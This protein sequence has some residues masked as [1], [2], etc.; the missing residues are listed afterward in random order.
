MTPPPPRGTGQER[1]ALTSALGKAI[2]IRRLELGLKRND[3]R[4]RSGLSY[5]YIAE[6]E[7]GSKAASSK[8]LGALAEALELSVSELMARAEEL[9]DLGSSDAFALSSPREDA[10]EEPPFRRASRAAPVSSVRS[11]AWRSETRRR[12]FGSDERPAAAPMSASTPRRG[13]IADGGP[14]VEQRVREV[15]R[16][17]LRRLGLL[18]KSSAIQDDEKA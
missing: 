1:A 16:D 2:A 4:D 18:P 11:D 5:P 10:S 17:E 13:D 8:A 7:N 15:V 6:L 9:R 12:W 3:L 14:L